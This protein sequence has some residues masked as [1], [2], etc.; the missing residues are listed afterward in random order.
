MRELEDSAAGRTPPCPAGRMS[1]ALVH[2]SNMFLLVH[3][4]RRQCCVS[5]VGD[6]AHRAWDD[7]HTRQHCFPI[8]PSMVKCPN[9]NEENPP[10]FRLCGYCGTPLHAEAQAQPR[11]VRRTLSFIFCDLKDSTA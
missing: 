11:V 9:C 5:A 2:A 1:E 6:A 4:V 3:E 7:A 10:K 8:L